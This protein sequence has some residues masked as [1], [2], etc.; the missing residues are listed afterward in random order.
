[1]GPLHRQEQE[2]NRSTTSFS[3]IAPA[4]DTPAVDRARPADPTHVIIARFKRRQKAERLRRAAGIWVVRIGLAGALLCAWEYLADQKLIKEFFFSKPSVVWTYL[5][6]LFASGDVWIHLAATMEGTLGGFLLGSLLAIPFGLFLARF[7]LVDEILAPFLAGL[8]AL[9][10]VALAPIFIL[11]F[12]I[13]LSSKVFLVFSLV[14]F[15][16]LINTQ[17][18]VKSADEELLRMATVMGATPRQRFL[19]VIL[20]GAVPSIFAGLRVGIIYALLGTVVGEMVAAPAGLG[21]QVAYFSGTYRTGGVF[22][23]LLLLSL[24]GVALNGV[25]LFIERYLLRWQR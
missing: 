14:F 23:I 13:G 24:I 21:Q 25:T 2:M 5:E 15:I 22:A 6:E 17:A 16:V 18:G 20:P 12:G 4:S 9:P 8:N 10:R 7:P 19:K 1:M 11:W 3:A